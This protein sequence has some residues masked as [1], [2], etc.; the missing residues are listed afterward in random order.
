ML[1]VILVPSPT[2]STDGVQRYF[3]EIT[4]IPH[5][6]GKTVGTLVISN[7]L[8]LAKAQEV[9]AKIEDTL[10]AYRRPKRKSGKHRPKTFWERIL[11]EPLV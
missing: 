9:Q 6:Y 5:A 3:V 1:Q 7:A 11:R 8:P 2:V 10:D 4:G